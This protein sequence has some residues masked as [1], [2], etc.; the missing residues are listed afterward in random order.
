MERGEEFK[1]IKDYVPRS[2]FQAPASPPPPAPA[3]VPGHAAAPGAAVPAGSP[4]QPVRRLGTL[5][6]AP[7]AARCC[8]ALIVSLCLSIE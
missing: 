6:K 2:R 1:G 8:L 3:W 7:Q 5:L 4:T